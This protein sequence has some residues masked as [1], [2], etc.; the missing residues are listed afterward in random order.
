MTSNLSVLRPFHF[1]LRLSARL[2]PPALPCRALAGHSHWSNIK[3]KKAKTDSS[4]EQQFQRIALAI[5]AAARLHPPLIAHE[6]SFRLKAALEEARRQ[7]LPKSRIEAALAMGVRSSRNGR[8]DGRGSADALGAHSS[9]VFEGELDGGIGVLVRVSDAVDGAPG[10]GSAQEVRGL[11]QKVG[12]RV[13]KVGW[14]FDDEWRVVVA[15]G[16]KG[17]DQEGMLIDAAIDAGATDVLHSC[18]SYAETDDNGVVR[19]GYGE[20]AFLVNGRTGAIT[21]RDAITSCDYRRDNCS[22]RSE[23]RWRVRDELKPV[24]E[25]TQVKLSWLCGK[26]WQRSD[27][28]DVIHNASI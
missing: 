11:F 1:A 22:V 16:G 21:V 2:H 15:T 17:Q 10:R 8:P 7:S 26:L 9:R 12:G 19:S 5:T 27:V 6:H 3:H 24:D 4:R 13:G 18:E 14:L 20:L 23:R 28:V 25:A